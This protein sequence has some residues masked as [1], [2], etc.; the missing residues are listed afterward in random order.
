LKPR[1]KLLLDP[2]L[3]KRIHLVGFTT[4]MA[5]FYS[6]C[7]CLFL[8]SREDPYPSV[9]TE[10]MCV[11]A[12][13]V[14]F[15]K[16]TGYDSL[17]SEYGHVVDRNDVA[18]INRAIVHS[19]YNDSRAEKIARSEYVDKHCRYDDYCF[20]L[21][22]MLKPDTK[23]VS[24]VV[25]NYNYEEYMPSR[26][27]SVFDQTYPVFET[28]V[29]D[30]C[31]KDDSVKVIGDT[32][33]NANRY[34]NLI[35]N[36]NNSGNVFHQWKK[37]MKAS[38]GDFVWVAEADD[39]AEPEFVARTI[40]SMD[41]N[42]AMCFTNSK[43]IGTDSELLAK[44]YNYYY[45]LIDAALFQ[46]DFKL[47]GPEFVKR[48][49]AIKNVILN[50]SS[51]MWRRD[52]LEDALDEVGDKLFDLKLVGDWRL[53]VQALS[54]K[55]QSIAYIEDSLNTHRRHDDSVTHS[56]DHDAHLKE[57]K[58]IHALISETIDADDDVVDEMER[59]VEELRVQ[60]SKRP[61]KKPDN[62]KAAA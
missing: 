35:E 2:A 8:S 7:D 46:D 43:Q 26:L 59:Y 42:T 22:K 44:D 38:R 53:Y 54:K 30:D 24:V 60:L 5:D 40:E 10:A 51:V 1:D 57:I 39:L 19:L 56:L 18:Q 21:L 61:G 28:I 41:E 52:A 12:P 14:L 48:A 4:K 36:E 45:R 25:P 17:I 47:D 9:V 37:G 11:G 58:A 34:I 50:V 27:N 13:V 62:K 23:K 55:G 16:A 3:E 15:R 29:L 6:A 49:L 33:E 20:G 31:S 32:A